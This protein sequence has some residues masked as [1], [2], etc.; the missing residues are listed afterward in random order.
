MTLSAGRVLLTKAL[1]LRV[2]GG[3]AL[4]A[5]VYYSLT[6]TALLEL[7]LSGRP[8][9]LVEL[10]GGVSASYELPGQLHVHPI[11]QSQSELWYPSALT[12]A[13]LCKKVYKRA[14]TRRS[15]VGVVETHVH[16][17]PGGQIWVTINMVETKSQ[18]VCS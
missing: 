13:A 1:V 11:I 5:A 2:M 9:K 6:A 4:A 18:I 17:G 12:K 7:H 16:P 14:L 15:G 10:A 3:L 8:V